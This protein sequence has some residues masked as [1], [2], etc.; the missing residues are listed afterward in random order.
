M[1]PTLGGV[2]WKGWAFAIF[3]FKGKVLQFTTDPGDKWWLSVCCFQ[4]SGGRQEVLRGRS[5]NGRMSWVSFT[6]IPPLVPALCVCTWRDSG[7]NHLALVQP[8]Q[9]EGSVPR[10]CTPPCPAD[11]NGSRSQV[12][13]NFCPTWLQIEVPITPSLD[14]IICRNNSQNPG[15]HGLRWTSLFCN[16]GYD[17]RHDGQEE[18]HRVKS[19]RVS[20]GQPLST[21]SWGVPLSQHGGVSAKLEALWTLCFGDFLQPSSRRGVCVSHSVMSHSWRLHG[22]QSARLLCPWNSPGNNTGVG[23]LSF[24]QEIFLTQGLNP[25]LLHCR[26]SLYHMSYQGSPRSEWSLLNLQSVSPSLRM[27]GQLKIPSF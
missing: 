23:C 15:N 24:L 17:K 25:G 22:L 14:S 12:T 6:L 3:F 21:R 1:N 19:G 16:K 10:D 26:Q 5:L 11:V 27:E 7:T 2:T 18:T 13:Y 4:I 9:G 20:L 8:L